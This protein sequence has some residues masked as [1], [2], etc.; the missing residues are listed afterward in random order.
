MAT[1]KLFCEKRSSRLRRDLNSFESTDIIRFD[2][3]AP[4]NPR[5][6]FY[7]NPSS[8]SAGSAVS[9]A[10]YSWLDFAIGTDTGGSIRHPAGVCGV[11][12]LRPST[13]AIPTIGLYTVSAILDTVGL[14]ARSASI[15]EA[16]FNCMV[17]QSYSSLAII[18]PRPKYKL[19]YPI[20]AKGT[21]PE[22]SRH[23]F[24]F[25]GEPGV[26]TEAESRF[27]D[28]IRKMEI[29]IDCTR[30]SFNVDDLWRETRPHGQ[31]DS[32]D[33]ATG[34]IY[35]VLTTYNCVR[36]TIDPFIAD[37]RA[38]NQGRS[39]FID[40]VVKARQAHGRQISSTQN[41]DAMETA[42]MFSKWVKETLL[43]QSDKSELPLLV[44]P[45]SWGRPE[46]RVDPDMG[47]LF[48]S[49][50]SSY[51]LSYLSGCPDCTIPIGEIETHSRIR[52]AKMS[53]P[54]SLSILSPPGTDLALL[55]LLKDLEVEGILK[56]PAAG[57]LMY[58]AG[59]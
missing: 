2:Y 25:P 41:A 5:G 43:A 20:R 33:V 45:Q 57:A 35:T 13:G 40:P 48:F 30:Q 27:E 46:Y 52:E 39:P 9:S 42:Q 24:P 3:P 49:S 51:S 23:W 32:L 29:W 56:S 17:K 8:S 34:H 38:A 44:F 11:Y 6:D 58:P 15:I 19:L 7:Q 55:A 1:E 37:F 53:L 12:G 10:A 50:F 26:A 36:E 47:N 28:F 22:H 59:K 54:I 31:S 18:P 16:A 21:S 4:F 14:L